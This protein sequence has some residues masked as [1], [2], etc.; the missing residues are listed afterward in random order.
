MCDDTEQFTRVSQRRQRIAQF[1]GQ[2]RQ[3]FVLLP[4]RD[5]QCRSGFD[6][7]RDITEIA[8]RTVATLRQ[9]DPADLPLVMF[10]SVPIEPSFA[11]KVP[12]PF[13]LLKYVM[14]ASIMPYSVTLRCA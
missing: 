5:F 6:M 2:H 12:C 13:R 14:P 9:R 10:G 8:H 11:T 7:R 4:V 1:V 3:E